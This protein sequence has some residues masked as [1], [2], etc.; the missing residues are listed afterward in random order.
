MRRRFLGFVKAVAPAVALLVLAPAAATGTV[1]VTST[2]GTLNVAAQ[3]VG[4]GVSVGSD[5]V[6]MSVQ[7]FFGDGGDY[8]GIWQAGAGETGSAAVA[9]RFSLSVTGDTW[10]SPWT[11][12]NLSGTSI[13]RIV[14]DAGLGNAVFDRTFDDLF[15]T[16]D[17]FRGKDFKLVGLGGQSSLDIVATYRDEVALIDL[18]TGAIDPVV[19]DLFRVLDIELTGETGL[20]AGAFFRFLAD[21]DNAPQGVA[22]AV[23]EPGLVALLAFGM[24]VAVSGARRRRLQSSPSL[25][26]GSRAPPRHR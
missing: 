15:G 18:D 16:F 17:S 9:D 22:V 3:V 6:G 20:T 2:P 24:A 5:M 4:Q 14:I 25:M 13:T 10:Y 21:T 26:A 1:I 12:T 19:G 23:S 8:T 7:V 11:F